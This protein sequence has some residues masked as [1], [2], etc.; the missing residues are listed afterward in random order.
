[1][2]GDRDSVNIDIEPIKISKSS[3]T[4]SNM[5]SSKVSSSSNTKNNL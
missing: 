1:M 3:N 4:S 5:S 2:I